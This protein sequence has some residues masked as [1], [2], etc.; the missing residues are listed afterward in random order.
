MRSSDAVVRCDFVSGNG[1][2][3]IYSIFIP[4]DNNKELKHR[5]ERDMKEL[6]SANSVQ[7]TIN[8]ITTGATKSM[9][10]KQFPADVK[11]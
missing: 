6:D 7:F 2:V 9:E 1:P 4:D 11:R 3:R 8:H 10:Q 5:L